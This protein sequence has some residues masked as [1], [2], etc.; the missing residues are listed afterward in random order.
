MKLAEGLDYVTMPQSVVQQFESAWTT[1]KKP[2]GGP[3]WKGVT[4]PQH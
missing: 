1:I 4:E 3:A 2:D